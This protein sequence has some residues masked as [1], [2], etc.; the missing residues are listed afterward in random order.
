VLRLRDPDGIIVKLVG[1]DLPATAPLP[2]P[3]APTRLRGATLL[4]ADPGASA[5]F[6]ARFG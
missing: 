1:V 5:A 3:M 6:L 4:S 2:D